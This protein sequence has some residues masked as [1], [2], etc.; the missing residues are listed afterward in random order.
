MPFPFTV[1]TAAA[2]RHVQFADLGAFESVLVSDAYHIQHDNMRIGDL[3]S[4]ASLECDLLVVVGAPI[5][6][7]RNNDIRRANP[8]C[9]LQVLMCL[10]ERVAT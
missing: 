3:R 5:G 2:I 8:N 4:P 1:K 10:N 9:S 7:M 6:N